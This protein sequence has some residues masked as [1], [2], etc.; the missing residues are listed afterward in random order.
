MRLQCGDRFPLARPREPATI[1]LR[2]VVHAGDLQQIILQSFRH[3]GYRH[4]LPRAV[5]QPQGNTGAGITT[6]EEHTGGAF[7]TGD[8]RYFRQRCQVTL[9]GVGQA[10]AECKQRVIV[11]L[12]HVVGVLRRGTRPAEAQLAGEVMLHAAIRLAQQH[13]SDTAPFRTWQPGSHE[14]IGC[15]DLAVHP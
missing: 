15:I 6:C 3:L 11:L 12:P 4:P 10:E 1:L 13:V 8:A 2:K 9:V 5:L 7:L 14:R